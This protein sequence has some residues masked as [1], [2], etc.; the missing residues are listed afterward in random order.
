MKTLLAILLIAVGGV[1][2]YQGWNRKNSFAGEAA[3]ATT[4]VANSMD[5]GARTP[6]H[7][8]SMV[9][10]GALILL[11]IGLTVRRRPVTTVIR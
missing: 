9:A 1:L 7:V 8:V 4:S 2:L 6:R 10:G 3:T 11:G 5:G